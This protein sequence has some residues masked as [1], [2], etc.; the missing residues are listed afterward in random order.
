VL[1]NESN[2]TLCSS[3]LNFQPLNRRVRTVVLSPPSL[4][5]G[6]GLIAR[7][8]V[9]ILM[10]QLANGAPSH[11][12][13]LGGDLFLISIWAIIIC[14]IFGPILLAALVRTKGGVI[15]CDERWGGEKP[16]KS[17]I[18]RPNQTVETSR[19]MSREAT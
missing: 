7:G 10:I 4:L 6:L 2:V 1:P 12:T 5:L 15:W 18:D 13:I 8:E 17:P 16:L 11:A 19:N 9:C 3:N 14:T